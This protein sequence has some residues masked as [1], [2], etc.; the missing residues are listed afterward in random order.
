MRVLVTGGAGYVGG[1]AARHLLARGHD[2]LMLDDLSQGHREAVPA[3]RLV[4]GDIGDRALVERLLREHGTEAVMHFAASTYVGESV[5]DPERYWQNNVAN[6]LAL[7]GAMRRAGVARIVF[8]STCSLYGEKAEMPL[9]EATALDPGNPYA[10]TKHAIER[11]IAD[12][13]RAYGL[14]HMLLRYFNASGA[15][16]DGRHGEDH[17][18]EAHLIPILLQA[19]LGQRESIDVFGDDYPTPDGTCVRDYVHV[20]DLAQA[21]ELAL[22]A[23][24]EPGASPAG[25][26]F[27]IGTGTGH[28][29]LEVIHAVE[30]ITG[31]KVPYRVVG[32]RAG[33]PP[34]LVASCERLTGELGWQPRYADLNAIVESAWAWHR[35]HPEG[36]AS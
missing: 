27:N 6:T 8:S 20:I 12:F 19:A 17:R 26:I 22:C 1:F 21:H 28:S 15:E 16:P 5:S 10:V 36:Y 14:G 7:L 24:P 25:R 4:V 34:R 3:E 31:H 2:V 32:R 29:V 9:T 30:R 33:D 11:M 18:P 13:A 23:C 35:S